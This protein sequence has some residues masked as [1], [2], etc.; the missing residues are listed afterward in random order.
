MEEL[1]KRI[2]EGLR[3]KNLLNSD[4][5]SKISDEI[6]KILENN[7]IVN[8][9]F[10]KEIKQVLAEY[11]TKV[12][13]KYLKLE[14]STAQIVKQ[15]LKDYLLESI[16]KPLKQAI[17]EYQFSGGTFTELIK[18]TTELLKDV[19]IKSNAT[20][21]AKDTLFQYRRAITYKSSI[22]LGIKYFKYQGE[23]I[24]TTRC[25]CLQRIGNI[26]D[27]DEI[28]KW[29]NLKWDGKISGTNKFNIF[30][31][32]GGYNCLHTLA[33]VSEKLAKERG[34]NKYNPESCDLVRPKK[35]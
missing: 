30:N 31:R 18:S 23:E 24:D 27:I 4:D 28:K 34:I 13:E 15:N 20:M 9:D 17:F 33:P 22:D 35:K 12:A 32:L 1:I 25:F 21:V 2:L 14:A 3:D 5:W 7:D 10:T 29:A 6:D 11:P 19:D 8:E 16:G 26:Y